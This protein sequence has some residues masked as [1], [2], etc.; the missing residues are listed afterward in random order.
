M[1]NRLAEIK[2]LKDELENEEKVIKTNRRK[3]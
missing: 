3:D 2:Y 1:L